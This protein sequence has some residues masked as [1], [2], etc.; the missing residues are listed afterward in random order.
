VRSNKD[1]WMGKWLKLI[2]KLMRKRKETEK[3]QLKV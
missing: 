2:E 3:I 1:G